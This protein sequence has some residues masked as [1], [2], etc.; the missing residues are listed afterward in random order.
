[1]EHY[2]GAVYVKTSMT[3]LAIDPGPTQSTYVLWDGV[4]ILEK[5]IEENDQLAHMIGLAHRADVHLVI[6]MIGH[7]GS[8]MPAGKEV[9]ETC[10]WIGRFIECWPGQKHELLLRATIKTHLCGSA[11]AKDQN[12]R[13]ALIDRFGVT[14]TKKAPGVLYGVS[15]HMWAALA[16]AVCAYD[17][18]VTFNGTVL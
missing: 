10:I 4:K 9:F 1:V 8:G 11:R 18:R 13:Q 5:G 6:E 16:V 17:R 2:A 14:G 12:V 3:I 15:S 7:Y